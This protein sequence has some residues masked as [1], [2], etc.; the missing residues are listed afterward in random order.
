MF[1]YPDILSIG[2]M[3]STH[4][5]GWLAFFFL[6]LAFTTVLKVLLSLRAIR[7]GRAALALSRTLSGGKAYVSNAKGAIIGGGVMLAVSLVLAVV[8]VQKATATDWGCAFSGDAAACMPVE[9]H[10][11]SQCLHPTVDR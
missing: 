6:L 11:A 10:K 7:A 9:T 5:G 3:S 1:L 4:S 2:W 8:C